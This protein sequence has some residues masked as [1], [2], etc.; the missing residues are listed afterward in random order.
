MLVLNLVIL[1]LAITLEPIPFTVFAVVLA[2][3]DG[4][5]KAA[6]FIAGWI[7]SL[8][9]VVTLTLAVTGNNPPKPHTAPSAAA[10]AA[11]ILIGVVLVIIAVRRRR[12]IG[13]PRKPKDPPKWQTGV[14]SMSRWFAAVVAVL[15]QPWGLVAVGVADVTGA[16]LTGAASTLALVMFCVLSTATYLAT[17]IY[18]WVRPD[19]TRALLVRI[20]AWITGHTDQVIVILSVVFGTWLIVSSVY[21]LA[22]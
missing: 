3:K 12:R 22:T 18:A 14:D 11:K 6:F 16:K 15:V 2:S 9:A 5:S 8:A 20:R 19:E 17:E 10:L 7:L 21:V 1:G 13:R 4:T